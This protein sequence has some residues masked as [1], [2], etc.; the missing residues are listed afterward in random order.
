LSAQIL[1]N[2]WVNAVFVGKARQSYQVQ[3]S[4]DFRQWSTLRT[5]D[6]P[7]GRFEFLDSTAPIAT[8]RFYR[9]AGQ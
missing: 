8:S 1:S 4:T 3:V 9:V 6:A 7:Y 5:N 2:G